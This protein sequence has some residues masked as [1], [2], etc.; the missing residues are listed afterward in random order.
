MDDL[1]KHPYPSPELAAEHPFVPLE[2]ERLDL[3]EMHRRS[4]DFLQQPLIENLRWLR[5]V[6]DTIFMAG[7]A[8]FAWFVLGLYTGRSF[9]PEASE[10][11]PEPDERILVGASH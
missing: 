9:E 6:G 1:Y 8:S 7:V 11:A 10:P 3:D 4:A 2:H 5:I